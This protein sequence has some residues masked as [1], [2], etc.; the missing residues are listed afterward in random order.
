MSLNLPSAHRA[1]FPP[2]FA[3]LIPFP[4]KEC[5]R[6]RAAIYEERQRG[7]HRRTKYFSSPRNNISA[8]S[9]IWHHKNNR[10]GSASKGDVPPN[11]CRK[12]TQ[13]CV[14]HV[15]R[16]FLSGHVCPTLQTGKKLSHIHKTWTQ[17]CKC[18][19]KQ[20]SDFTDS[21]KGDNE[22]SYCYNQTI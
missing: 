1:T 16:F 13:S 2:L 20:W 8:G 3:Q 18:A 11:I 15:V 14:F 10:R 4:Y 5:E 9:E 12:N 7:K 6:Q 21:N 17:L 22:D 19:Q